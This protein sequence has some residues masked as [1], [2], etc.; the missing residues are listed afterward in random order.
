MKKSVNKDIFDLEIPDS[1]EPPSF[2]DDA[3]MA[4]LYDRLAWG[5]RLTSNEC[6]STYDAIM[7]MMKDPGAWIVITNSD[8]YSPSALA[9]KIRRGYLT[10]SLHDQVWIAEFVRRIGGEV[11]DQGYIVDR[12][13]D[14]EDPEHW[15]KTLK[16]INS[17]GTGVGVRYARSVSPPEMY[18]WLIRLPFDMVV[19]ET[20]HRLDVDEIY[21]VRD[22]IKESLG[23]FWDM[24]RAKPSS[25]KSGNK[26]RQEKMDR[27]YR[28]ARNEIEKL[29]GLMRRWLH[30]RQ[31]KH[32]EA[33]LDNDRPSGRLLSASSPAMFAAIGATVGAAASFAMRQ[34]LSR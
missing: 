24:Y 2:S 19:N 33:L 20:T 34:R 32:I 28:K 3:A 23:K 31:S 18:F 26:S 30:A 14:A 29:A 11:V 25:T 8:L 10:A 16:H 6:K 27:F 5:D 21:A 13:G 22:R 7:K 4:S 15:A 1:T 17:Y 12:C 9:E